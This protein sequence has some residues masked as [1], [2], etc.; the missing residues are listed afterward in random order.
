MTSYSALSARV[1]AAHED[2]VDE[3]DHDADEPLAE[4][5]AEPALDVFGFPAGS[6][7]GNCL[8][9]ILERH[10]EHGGLEAICREALAR[11]GIDAKWLPVAESMVHNAW[12]SPLGPVEPTFRLADIDRPVAEMEFH[13]PVRRFRGDRLAE[14]LAAHGYDARVPEDVQRINGFLHGFIDLVAQHGGRWY[15]LD[16]KSNWLGG[17]VEA[18]DAASI[19]ASMRH[20]G[21]HLQY[22][23]YLTALDRLLRLRLPDYDYD[24]HIG[25]ACYLFLRGMHPEVPGRGVHFDRPSRQCIAAIDDCLSGGQDG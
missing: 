24:R 13:L 8:H 4:A 2:A 25:G 23:L 21:Y 22:L 3:P 17:N 9:E 5:P 14:I 15:V 10:V 7:P 16:Y 6:R 18:Y 12:W 20:H 19:Q 1:S 11:H